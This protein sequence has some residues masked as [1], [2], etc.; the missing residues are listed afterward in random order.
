MSVMFPGVR[1]GLSS[2]NDAVRRGASFKNPVR[3]RRKRPGKSVHLPSIAGHQDTSVG[4][5]QAIR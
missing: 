3:S 2:L 5:K 1:I 4:S